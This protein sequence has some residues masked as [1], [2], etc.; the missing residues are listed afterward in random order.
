MKKIERR[1]NRD[2]KYSTHSI[3]RRPEYPLITNWIKKKSKVVDLGCG[4][5]SLLAFLKKQKNLTRAVGLEISPSGVRSARKKG[6]NV[7][8]AR[9]DRRLPFKN[10]EFDYA[11][12]NVT[13]QMVMYPEILIQEMV[14]VSK[15]QIITF[16]NFA[17]ILNRLDLLLRGRMP[18]F[19]IPG[20]RWYSTGHIHQLSIQDF[21]DF[22]KEDGIKILESNHI[23]PRKFLIVPGCFLKYFPNLF[24]STGVFLTTER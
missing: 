12:C 7:I 23:Y 5:G 6:V 8:R 10:K 15:K 11:I 21:R 24:A 22:C 1:D 18:R 17:F 3:S 9:I 20:Y 14:R 2:Y 19:M 4:D 13:L 16:P